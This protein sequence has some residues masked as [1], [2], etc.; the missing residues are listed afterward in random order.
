MTGAI[1]KYLPAAFSLTMFGI[2]GFLAY[3]YYPE[4]HFARQ[5][6]AAIDCKRVQDVHA[7]ATLAERY[8]QRQGHYPLANRQTVVSVIITD[9]R[10]PKSYRINPPREIE[11]ELVMADQFEEEVSRVLNTAIQLPN[12]PQTNFAWEKRF[13]L[14]KTTPDGGY[15]VSGILFSAT[16]HTQK[17]ADHRHR[18]QVGS[19]LSREDMTRPY[20]DIKEPQAKCGP[21]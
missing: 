18:Y 19:T 13:Y 4:N 20:S 10:L 3:M 14:Y 15:K 2:I 6:Q 12:D 9:K 21:P 16:T 8:Q 1:Q 7:I 5:Y 11:G 17:E